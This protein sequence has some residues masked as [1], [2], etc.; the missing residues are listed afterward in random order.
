MGEVV[1]KIVVI[2]HMSVAPM[3]IWHA[4]GGEIRPGELRLLESGIH[5]R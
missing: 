1:P 4:G 3:E 2:T 5:G